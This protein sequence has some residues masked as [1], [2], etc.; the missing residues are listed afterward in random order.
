MVVAHDVASGRVDLVVVLAE[1]AHGD[2]RAGRD[3]AAV[4]HDPEMLE[5]RIAA[6]QLL[7]DTSGVVGVL[8]SSEAV[9]EHDIAE[10]TLS[11]RRVERRAQLS[12]PEPAALVLVEVAIDLEN[13]EAVAEHADPEQLVPDLRGGGQSVKKFVVQHRVDGR[14]GGPAL[15]TDEE[16]P[17]PLRKG[18][19]AGE[20]AEDRKSTRLNSSHVKISYAVFCLKKKKKN[21]STTNTNN[22]TRH[23]K[24]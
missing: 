4:S 5:R 14:R 7:V 9:V 1:L 10:P 15:R 13:R 22:R 16:L 2:G 18:P 19:D 8:P 12:L 20:R 24:R 11:L 21:L 3:A 23:S 17:L 6:N